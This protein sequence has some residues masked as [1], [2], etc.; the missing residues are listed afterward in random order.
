MVLPSGTAR[1][2]SAAESGAGPAKAGRA[3]E[4]RFA[5]D[6]EQ[7]SA[8]SFHV[9]PAIPVMSRGRS[10]DR[11]DAELLARVIHA[12]ARGEPFLGQ[13]AVGAV[14]INRSRDPRFPSTVKGVVFQNGALCTVR[15]GQILL[16]PDRRA[17]KA[18]VLALAGVDP[19]GGAIY[20]YNPDKATSTW[21][22]RR[23][24]R[25]QIGRHRFAR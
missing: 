22:R 5:H 17:Y 25:T 14:I 24:T 23:P 1:V 21:I 16:K 15:D 4:E 7:I 6:D 18:A 8:S 20:F 2:Y 11:H 19:S 13:V 12:E 10:F 3:G 9:R